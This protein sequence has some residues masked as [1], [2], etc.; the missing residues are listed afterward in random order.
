M[1]NKIIL[2]TTTI[3]LYSFSIF[4][5]KQKLI[6]GAKTKPC[7]TMFLKEDCLQVKYTKNQKDWENFSSDIKG[8]NYI[9]G[10]EYTLLVNI[11]KIANPPADA[12]SLSYTLLKVLKKTK[13]KIIENGVD[14]PIPSVNN[15]TSTSKGLP[16]VKNQWIIEHFNSPKN[17]VLTKSSY[18]S[19]DEN[20]T[21]FHG[22]DGCNNIKGKVILSGNAIQFKNIAGT[23]MM[24]ENM[25][26]ANLFNKNLLEIN[27][28]EIKGAELFL[29]KDDTLVM[30][31]ESFR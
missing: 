23:K 15:N 30:T 16:L 5:K 13:K 12:S 8:F 21:T 20:G 1:N 9:K 19:I 31:M 6:I 22:K 4:A 14:L 29:Y 26:Q 27:R 10:Y 2:L 18:F 28:Y 24:C 17:Q 11:E 25:E 3:L 7:Q